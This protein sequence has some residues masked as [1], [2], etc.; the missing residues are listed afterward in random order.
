LS[1]GPCI[2]KTSWQGVPYIEKSVIEGVSSPLLENFWNLFSKM[3]SVDAKSDADIVGQSDASKVTQISRGNSFHSLSLFNR[4]L[5]SFITFI[6]FITSILLS[7]QSSSLSF[8]LFIIHC[9]H[10]SIIKFFKFL[11]YFLF[12]H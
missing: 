7:F 4:L 6:T 2:F 5:H 8:Q 3:S 10:S 9:I 11:S 12:I 1:K